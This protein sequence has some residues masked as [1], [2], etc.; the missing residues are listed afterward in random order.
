MMTSSGTTLRKI[1]DT[2]E[3]RLDGKARVVDN[4]SLL[5]AR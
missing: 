5:S 3:S 4:G 1:F 2:A